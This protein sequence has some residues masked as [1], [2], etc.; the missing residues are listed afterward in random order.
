MKRKGFTL[1]ELLVVIAIIA[2]L[3]GILMPALA[4]VRQIAHRVVCGTNLSAIG[5]A[6]LIYSNDSDEEFPRA[7]GSGIV[8]GESDPTCVIWD[9]AN[10]DAAF[11]S[12]KATI[13]SSF[14]LLIK[15]EDMGV[16]SFICKSD[17]GTK[18]F[19][20]SDYANNLPEQDLIYAW[21]F[22]PTPNYHCSYSYHVPYSDFALTTASGP[23]MAMAADR[24]PF[25][26]SPY[27]QTS[28]IGGAGDDGA[29]PPEF[30][31]F[32]HD[33][34]N[35]DRELAKGGN[36][37]QHQ[38]EGQNVLFA[39]IH[40][41][42]EK[43]SFCGLNDDNIYTY[44]TNTPLT[45]EQDRQEGIEPDNVGDEPVHRKDS[46]LVHDGLPGGK[47]IRCFPADTVVWVDGKMVPFLKVAP[48]QEL[49]GKLGDATLIDP[50]DAVAVGGKLVSILDVV[51]RE[52][53]KLDST[54]VIEMIEEHGVG[55][56]DCYDMVLETGNTITIVHSHYFLTVS[57]KWVSIENL[58]SGSKLQSMK[59]PITVRSVVKRAMP[60]VG[61]AYNLK[62]KGSNCYF[63]GKD[64]VVAVDCSKLPGE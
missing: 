64:G 42:F 47:G 44:W 59:G 14:Y 53:G 62:I 57:G 63:V 36:C 34:D 31:V 39:D 48:G 13:G 23:G 56:Y 32:S 18:E 4:R 51:P 55:S 26:E 3:M 5:K 29:G 22:G 16:K 8:L 19:K 35:F 38:K 17:S 6:M 61:N 40:V 27:G 46:L 21:D 11:A 20:L 1:V 28:V 7:G 33:P 41:N 60:F 30:S 52:K 2:L 25:I 45:T 58:S 37:F 50:A 15:Y 10:E 24:N 54:A 43:Y 12:G 9:A 49:V